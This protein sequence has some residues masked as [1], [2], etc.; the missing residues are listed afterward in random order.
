MQSIGPNL[1]SVH[2]IVDGNAKY[3]PK[4]N[5]KNGEKTKVFKGFRILKKKVV[6][7]TFSIKLQ[8]TTKELEFDNFETPSTSLIPLKNTN[9]FNLQ[10]V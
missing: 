2:V 1:L 6:T 9:H 4:V 3:L 7:N 5:K 10:K 8:E